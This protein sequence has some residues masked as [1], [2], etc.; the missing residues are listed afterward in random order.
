MKTIKQI[1]L[2]LR[3]PAAVQPLVFGAKSQNRLKAV[4]KLLR[5]YELVGRTMTS[6]NVRF[7]PTIKRFTEHWQALEDRKKEDVPDIPK[8]TRALPAT[9]WTESFADFLHRVLGARLIVL[10][11]VIRAD[12]AV[13]GVEPPLAPG[14][15]YSENMVRS[16]PR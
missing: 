3:R 11:Y 8:I 7:D 10:F 16:R 15:P 12:V 9:K 5:Y 6:V 1:G 2:N 14:Q 4:A 13:P